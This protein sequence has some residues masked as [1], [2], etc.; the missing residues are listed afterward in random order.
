M[1]VEAAS[2]Q[3][4]KQMGMKQGRE[5]DYQ[6]TKYT[7]GKINRLYRTEDECISDHF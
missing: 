6:S 5:W 2:C 1:C 4:I 7:K 3:T